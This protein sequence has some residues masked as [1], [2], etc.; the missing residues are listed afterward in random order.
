MHPSASEPI[1]PY[2]YRHT[3]QSSDPLI[4]AA[5]R[6][7]ERAHAG[8][9]RG[10]IDPTIMYI[11]HP[12]MV[13]DL[14]QTMGEKDRILL[15]AAL[16][17]DTLEDYY[18]DHD[19]LRKDLY[20][21]L[22]RENLPRGVAQTLAKQTYDYVVEVTNPDSSSYIKRMFQS[23]HVLQMKHLPTMMLKMADQL[24]SV[25]CHLMMADN[26][27]ATPE[28]PQTFTFEQARRFANKAHAIITAVCTLAV[29]H[30]NDPDVCENMQAALKPW[31]E[32][33]DKI[34][35][36]YR[37][38]IKTECPK[39]P[40]E[41]TPEV[42]AKQKADIQAIR[43][44]F[45]LNAVLH[46]KAV[47]RA[48]WPIEGVKTERVFI[49]KPSAEQAAGLVYIDLDQSRN[50]IGYGMVYDPLGDKKEARNK[51]YIN[52]QNAIEEK[53]DV[54]V[55][56]EPQS[57]EM[58][59]TWARF[60]LKNVRAHRLSR[61]VP[62]EEFLKLAHRVKACT[63]VEVRSIMQEASIYINHKDFLPS[64]D[65][66]I[67]QAVRIALDPSHYRPKN[68]AELDRT[69]DCIAANVKGWTRR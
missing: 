34:Y 5:F 58:G 68:M 43:D 18:T 16:L 53:R 38:L 49:T 55:T 46:S 17:H 42:L 63:S 36:H 24:S 69:A 44:G 59:P 12:I 8:V 20:R 29:K 2:T 26:T 19:Q 25:I 66:N 60:E 32:L 7:A 33:Y 51:L 48:P 4:R 50:V 41:P 35:P 65:T 1:K 61:P 30:T 13:Y 54:Q 39:K 23:D 45:D 67:T 15:A 11:S 52:L 56:D 22:G 64:P 40:I 14:L 6:V 57:I 27:V 47:V 31:R 28:N 37:D 21:E 10:K 9:R 3:I 62:I